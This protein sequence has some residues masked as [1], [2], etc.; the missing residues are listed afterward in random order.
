MLPMKM[1]ANPLQ[2]R[3]MKFRS[4]VTREVCRDLNSFLT[5][6]DREGS[7][8]NEQRKEE[9]E[10]KITD[11][12]KRAFEIQVVWMRST[13]RLIYHTIYQSLLNLRQ[14]LGDVF[15]HPNGRELHP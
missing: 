9:L 13:Y 5:R 11:H 12:S 2:W 4:S 10:T 7:E 3:L 15:I 6:C 1:A 8:L 14:V